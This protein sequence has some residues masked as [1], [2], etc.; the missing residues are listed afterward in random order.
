MDSDLYNAIVKT[1]LELQSVKDVAATLEVS[2]V[3][4]RKV[5]ITE[6][7]WTSRTSK[8]VA[9]L[10]AEGLTTSQIAAQLCT[11]EKAVQQY[12]PYSRGLYGGE[13]SGEAVRSLDYRRRI[14]IARE[15]LIRPN[16]GGEIPYNMEYRQRNEQEQNEPKNHNIERSETMNII[17][18]HLEL[19]DE[20]NE[21]DKCAGIKYGSTITREILVP[22]D[23]QLW[24]LHYAI[25]AAFGW[26]NSHLH[27][28][29]LT[30]ER[31]RELTEDKC[32]KWATLVGSLL[33][34]PEGI[35]TDECHFWADDYE[36]GSIKTWLRKKYTGPYESQDAAEAGHYMKAAINY[37]LPQ[38]EGMYKVQYRQCDD[39]S[40]YPA[41]CIK[42][43]K[44]EKQLNFSWGDTEPI[45]ET[46]TMPWSE[47]PVC[48]LHCFFE[49]GYNYILERLGVAEVLSSPEKVADELIYKYDFGDDWKVS[50]KTGDIE[51]E[52]LIEAGR[53]SPEELEEAMKAVE[54]KYR[55]VMVGADGFNAIDDVGGIGGLG[56]FYRCVNGGE[57]GDLYDNKEEAEA[58][59]KGLGWSRRRVSL[60]NRL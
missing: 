32:G 5:L 33:R 46:K 4:V 8:Q 41:D 13:R 50:I 52:D 7:L 49:T 14:A 26:Q 18:L 36:S 2:P 40:V 39:G 58:W 55:P 31:F 47:L 29:E 34:V 28:F 11:T 19:V 15:H 17:R 22:S 48:F 53:L 23:I 24:A 44:E 12:L 60:K 54:E 6:C 45:V 16:S 59:A 3:K 1:F 35:E 56:Q 10:R 30:E 27:N 43:D 38:V 42:M 21:L 51:C 9:D 37:L 57:C 20:F 25:Q